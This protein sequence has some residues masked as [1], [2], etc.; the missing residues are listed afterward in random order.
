MTFIDHMRDRPCLEFL[1]L[2][3]PRPCQALWAVEGMGRRSIAGVFPRT[4][5]LMHTGLLEPNLDA[6][7]ATDQELESGQTTIN[8]MR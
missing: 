6:I 5:L 4:R 2:L 1:P 8:A 3:R 7:S